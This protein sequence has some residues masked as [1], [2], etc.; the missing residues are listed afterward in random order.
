M[1]KWTRKKHVTGS[2]YL[3]RR[4]RG[5][6]GT[7]ALTAGAGSFPGRRSS[8]LPFPDTASYSCTSWR[9]FC[10]SHA[11]ARCTPAQAPE[12]SFSILVFIFLY[13]KWT[14]VQK[15]KVAINR[16]P[17]AVA[18]GLLTLPKLPLPMTRRTWKWSKLTAKK[19]FKNSRRLFTSFTAFNGNRRR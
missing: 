19:K 4:T 5:W 3:G 7:D 12:T 11:S 1:I 16:R 10:P 17:E 15:C 6:R 9:T 2:I 18:S 14:D 13:K 8:W